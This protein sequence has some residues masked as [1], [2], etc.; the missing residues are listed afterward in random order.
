MT[1]PMTLV[2]PTTGEALNLAELDGAQLAEL[3]LALDDFR[4]R[5]GDARAQLV[6]EVARRADARGSRTVS[7]GGSTWTVNAP[8]DETYD[9]RT[10]RAG[11]DELVA[12]GLVDPELVDELITTPP[13]KPE[14]PRVDRRRIATLKR[15]AEPRVLAVI[16]A[17]RSIAPARRTAR[18]VD[19]AVNGTA[20][21]AGS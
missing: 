10:L 3:H 4:E 6:A 14:P 5:L 16:A 13:P 18:L 11:L 12:D 15:S 8:T 2:H 17:A 7:L 20:T 21:E 1:H 19:V 9:V